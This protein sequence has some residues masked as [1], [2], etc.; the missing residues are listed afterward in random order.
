MTFTQQQQIVAF[1]AIDIAKGEG[2]GRELAVIDRP[3]LGQPETVRSFIVLD[4]EFF[5]LAVIGDVRTFVAVEVGNHQGGDA[6]LRGNRVDAKARIRRQFVLLAFPA[7]RDFIRLP[8]LVIQQGNFRTSVVDD[9]QVL[10]T[11]A[12]QVGRPKIPDEVIDRIRFRPAE[13][14]RGQVG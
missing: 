12:V 8:G 6:F 1:I 9:D 5:W 13:P 11:I 2:V 14:E 7:R 4:H 10:Q 3:A